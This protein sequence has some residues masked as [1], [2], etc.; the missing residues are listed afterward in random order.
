MNL[1]TYVTFAVLFS[2]LG[3]GRASQSKS[4]DDQERVNALHQELSNKDKMIK[5]RTAELERANDDLAARNVRINEVTAKS[6]Q[7]AAELKALGTQIEERT[8]AVDAANK[9]LAGQEAKVVALHAKLANHDAEVA[10]LSKEIEAQKRALKDATTAN[11]AFAAKQAELVKLLEVAIANRQKAAAEL[12]AAAAEKARMIK[13]LAGYQGKSVQAFLENAGPETMFGARGVDVAESFPRRDNQ[14]AVVIDLGPDLEV[15]RG[16]ERSRLPKLDGY[17]VLPMRVDYRKIAICDDGNKIE[18]QVEQGQVYKLFGSNSERELVGGRTIST[19]DNQSNDMKSKNVFG[20][21]P[22]QMWAPFRGDMDG[23][24][25][26]DIPSQGGTFR[27]HM[28]S[29]LISATNCAQAINLGDKT[30]LITLACM[31][32]SGSEIEGKKV[33]KGCFAKK[34]SWGRAN[35]LFSPE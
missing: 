23:I 27:L 9:R 31:V 24:E 26:M 13:N 22:L 5:S 30:D 29:A 33:S 17:S 7:Q 10:A 4:N 8:L 18:A 2:A 12:A 3:C 16:S 15:L 35:T 25:T 20:G 14:C 6:E 32:L 11:D 21:A 1:I 28:G 19:C 34:S